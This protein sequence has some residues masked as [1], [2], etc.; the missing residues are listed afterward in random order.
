MNPRLR[1]SSS[2]RALVDY[3][4]HSTGRSLLNDGSSLQLDNDGV[5]ANFGEVRLTSAFQPILNAHTLDVVAFEALLRAHT[6]DG[7]MLS[8]EHVFRLPPHADGLSFL[9]RLCRTMHAANFS[10]QAQARE[11][12]YINIHGRHLTNISEGHGQTFTALLEYCDLSPSRVVLEI[13]ESDI[14]DEQK[15][16]EAVASYQACGYRIAIDDFGCRHSNFDRLWKMSPEIVKLDRSLITQSFSNSRARIILPKLVELL[17]DL[18]A[19]VVCEGVETEDQHRLAVDVGSDL[20][21][22]YLYARPDSTL[23]RRNV[24]SPECV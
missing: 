15:L 12:L 13:L 8:P 23:F 22:G 11:L 7:Q 4:S 5:S 14:A 9:D 21:Q 20:V 18:G 16:T 24:L 17:H 19:K 6:E 10:T 1:P 3:F 2:L